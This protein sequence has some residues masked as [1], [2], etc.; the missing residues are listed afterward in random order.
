MGLNKKKLNLRMIVMFFLWIPLAQ[1][2]NNIQSDPIKF[3]SNSFLDAKEAFSFIVFS[4]EEKKQLFWQIA[5]SHYLYAHAFN[6]TW[7]KELDTEKSHTQRKLKFELNQ[8]VRLVDEYFGAVEVFYNQAQII[9]D[10]KNQLF[11][12]EIATG[13]LIIEYQGC[14]EAGLCYPTQKEIWD[15]KKDILH[16]K[17]SG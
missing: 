13:Y 8:G 2:S 5:P 17:L 15:L 10:L 3:D 4:S 11:D 7:M 9:L 12:D 6:I 1:G 14:A 16:S